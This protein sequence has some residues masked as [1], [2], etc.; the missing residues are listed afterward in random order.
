MRR[1]TRL[2]AGIVLVSG[3]GFSAGCGQ[4]NRGEPIVMGSPAMLFDRGPGFVGATDIGRG[5]WP[6]T[7]GS[8]ESVEETTFVEF[9]YD[10]QGNAYQ[11]DFTPYRNF[12]AYRTGRKT[13]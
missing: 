12:R 13:R 4:Y 10:R 6:S 8:L 9:Y 2:I 11:E 5:S 7:V 3:L 1:I